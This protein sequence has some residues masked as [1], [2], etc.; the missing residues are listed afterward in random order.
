MKTGRTIRFVSPLQKIAYAIDEIQ[1][2]RIETIQ[3]YTIP[4]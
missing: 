2:D 4:P 1:V 3:E